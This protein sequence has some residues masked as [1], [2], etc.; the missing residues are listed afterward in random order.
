[1]EKSNTRLFNEW[2]SKAARNKYFGH[3]F[4]PG[5][6]QMKVKQPGTNIMVITFVLTSLINERKASRNEYNGHNI[7]SG[8][9]INESSATGLRDHETVL[10]FK[11]VLNH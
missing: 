11:T 8:L 5:S 9:Y 3:I 4:A 10:T 2:I 1:M 7:C 6:I